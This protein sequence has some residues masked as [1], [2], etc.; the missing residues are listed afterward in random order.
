MTVEHSFDSDFTS[1]M[2]FL[3]EKYGDEIFKL[4]GIHPEQ[5][6]I[7]A[8]TREFF[9][10]DKEGK[11][12]SDVSIDGNANVA[13]KDTI[14]YAYE[15]SKPISKLNSLYNLWLT[16]KDLYGAEFADN[17][18]EA[19]ISGAIY[20]ND[21]HDIGRPYSYHPETSFLIREGEKGMIQHVTMSSLFSKYQHA[22][23]HKDDYE[24]VN[25]VP[26]NLLVYEDNKWVTLERI[27]RHISHTDLIWFET[28]KGHVF[29]VTEDHP[30]ILSDDTEKSAKD[31]VEGDCL[32]GGSYGN[33]IT[34]GIFVDIDRAYTIGAM[35]GDGSV[36]G[37]QALFHQKNVISSHFADVFSRVYGELSQK[38]ERKFMFGNWDTARWFVQNFGSNSFNRRLPS[39]YLNWIIPARKA[40]LAGIIDADGTVNKRTGV[41]DIRVISLALI[42]QVA[43]LARSVGCQRV[44]TSLA[45]NYQTGKERIRQLQPLYR[46]SFSLKEDEDILVAMSK[47][48]TDHADIVTKARQKDGRFETD[49]VN[50]I[51]KCTWKGEYVYD[52]TTSSGRFYS[53]GLIVHNCFNYSTYD[54]VLEGLRMSNRLDVDPPK[55]LVSFLHQVEQFV[56]YA[57]NSTL[58]ATGL[59]DLL[60]CVAGYV[61]AIRKSG[62]DHHI[63]VTDWEAY[64]REHLTSLIYTLNWEFRG[65]QSAFTNVS[66]YDHDFLE[67]LLPSYVVLGEPVDEDDA[68]RVQTIFLECMNDILS[69]TPI[70]FP[71]TTACFCVEENGKGERVVK[72]ERFLKEIAEANMKFGFINM[73]MGKSST[74]ASCCR[75]LSDSSKLGYSNSFG[76]GSTKIGSIGV[77]TLNLPHL[78]TR[79]CEI[80]EKNN[81]PY[82]ENLKTFLRLIQGMACTAQYINNA[83]REFLK[84]RISRGSLPLYTLGYMSLYHQYSTC[85]FTGMNEA[86][87]LLGYDIADE[88]GLEAAKEILKT[89]R[90]ANDTCHE[91]FGTPHNCEQIPAE[92][93]AVKLAAKDRTQGVW[94]GEEN[95]PALYAN[96]FIPLTDT[97][98][99]IFDRMKIQGELDRWCDGG[100]ILHLNLAQP[101]SS[102]DS[103]AALIK[104]AC[105]KGVVYFAIN[106]VLCQ[107]ENKHMFVSHNGADHEGKCPVCGSTN[108][109]EYTRVVGFL[110]NTK[111]WNKTR[112]T[113]DWPNRHFYSMAKE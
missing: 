66:V 25:L 7:N 12:T 91:K 41:I 59:A 106:L 87:M 100:S 63:H 54:I 109:D 36:D 61:Q 44:R 8:Y 95:A 1:L 2:N 93:A 62:Y 15:Q 83:K 50:K 3:F 81:Q 46:V 48:L 31:I 34:E 73:Y 26:F 94:D 53:N 78:A 57:A 23:Q 47:K 32:K 96:Q 20:I 105:K 6:D 51:E 85:G 10:M 42:Q 60:I 9:R 99:S 30:C 92:S 64:L 84:D 82:D 22:V 35:V 69:R 103:M 18:I 21:A 89:I 113:E 5:L 74:L 76:S 108:L 90:K 29:A 70:T 58:G 56:V 98:A 45:G 110:T 13:G 102:S 38:T 72:D 39:E 107:C 71:V 86:L 55:S 16:M 4:E 43:E 97:S 77:V 104:L 11:G 40:L 101:M 111:H 17:A 88:E 28:K 37:R 24:E 27:L 52:I 49:E 65:N 19:E 79:A 67:K 75:L 68:M 80:G 112:R 14:T 33:E